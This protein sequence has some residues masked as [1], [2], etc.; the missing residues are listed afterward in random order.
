MQMRAVIACVAT[1]TLTACQQGPTEEQMAKQGLEPLTGSEIR[2]VI[3]GNTTYET[4]TSNGTAWE[5]AGHYMKG[6]K[7]RGRAWWSGGQNEGRGTW[8]ID[9][10]LW[11]TEWGPQE[12]GNGDENCQKLYKEGNQLRYV[13]VDG[14]GDN[15]TATL[16]GG[17]PHD[18]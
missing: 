10:N 2:K 9:G 6:G 17:N 4:G 12:W 5:W 16:K 1:I 18:L 7:A 13:V 15:G 14:P 8:R 3:V 11:C